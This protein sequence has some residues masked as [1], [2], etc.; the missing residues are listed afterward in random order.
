MNFEDAL[1]FFSEHLKKDK[2]KFVNPQKINHIMEAHQLLSSMINSQDG[3]VSI[4]IREGALELGDVCIR[5]I[6]PQFTSY[7][8]AEFA[9]AI[10]NADHIDIYPTADQ[11]IKIDIMFSKA[12]YVRPL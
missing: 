9:L 2:I 3:D 8:T 12:Y 11:R 7:N 10:R 1:D 4:E 6:A 5:I